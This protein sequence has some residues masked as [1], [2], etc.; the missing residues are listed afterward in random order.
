MDV[1]IVGIGMFVDN[2]WLVAIPHLSIY[3]AASSSSCVWL[4]RS[5]GA[6]EREICR[7]GFSVLRFASR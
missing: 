2:V 1:C 3:L 6:G 7:T 5:S 4:R